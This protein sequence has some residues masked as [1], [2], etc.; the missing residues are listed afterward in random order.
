MVMVMSVSLLN[1]ESKILEKCIYVALYD[2]FAT[3]LTKHQH[4]FVK[5]RS[6]FTNLI[7][8]LRKVHYALDNDPNSEVIAFY[9]DFS[10]AF[11]NVPHFELLKKVANI[12]V[13]GCLLQFL[14][15]YL[16]NRKQF[17]RIDN[18]CFGLRDVNSG[19]S[20]GSLLGLLLFCIFINDVPDALKFSDPFIFAD[21]LKHPAIRKDHWTVQE[22]LDSVATWVRSNKMEL[23]LDKCAQIIFRGKKQNFDIVGEDLANADTVKDLWIHIKDDLS[24]SKHIEE[25]LRKA[26]K[27]LYHLRRNVAVEV[28]PLIKL[29]LYKSLILP[30]L[31]NGFTC[32]N[33]SRS[34]LQI[35]ER[36][37]K[38]AVK[39]IRGNKGMN[40]ISQLW[41]FN[42]LPLPM[43]LQVNNLLLLAK[44]M[45]ESSHC[46][47]LPDLTSAN[48][49]TKEVFR[50]QKKNKNRKS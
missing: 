11:D 36:F 23:A 44:F 29:G 1:I 48:R 18:T 24:W 22:D 3:F 45:H 21:D 6:V 42:I 39:W 13:V 40:Y 43:F 7:T 10:K 16:S 33:L 14:M 25:R 4:G 20:Q 37:Q 47:E 26:N 46:F 28:K 9:T 50:L 34:E 2:H 27:V 17:V 8:F 38:K 49:R 35:F 41:L 31:L 15:D 19:V 5:N 32:T 30:V 12:E